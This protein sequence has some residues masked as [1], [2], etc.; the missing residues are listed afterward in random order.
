MVYEHLPPQQQGRT[1]WKVVNYVWKKEYQ[2][3]GA[4]QHMLLW[5]EPG[6]FPDDA[7]VAEM[8]RPADTNSAVGKYL[9][10]MVRKL[11]ITAHQS[12]SRKHS[13][14]PVANASKAFPTMCPKR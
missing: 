14:R 1:T 4:V 2:K 12:A 13:A 3:C 5:I 10:K 11:M 9:R 6:T 8:P 7:V